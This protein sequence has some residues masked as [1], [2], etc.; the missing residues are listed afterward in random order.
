M[1]DLAS[2]SVDDGVPIA[3]VAEY[4]DRLSDASRRDEV[5]TL[6]RKQQR[7]L[8]R[9]ALAAP[10]I[11]LPHFVP[12]D[13]D[14]LVP[15]THFGKNT[16]P[17]PGKHKF[18]QKRF[19]R[20]SSGEGRLFGYNEAPSKGYVGPGYFVAVPTAGTPAWTERGPIVIDYFQVPD[21]PV[22]PGWPRVVPNT[23]G[24]QV[25]VY[26]KTRDF[27][28]KVSEHVSIGHAHKAEKSLDHYF[29]LVRQT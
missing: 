3:A 17:L 9:K 18:F 20:P 26:N 15:V 24:L 8:W 13:V 29:V 19:C 10:P 14:P 11:D 21:A 22:V 1:I 25:L 2:M 16:L 4:L 7:G 23:T 28:R 5:A 12:A 6:G 27:M